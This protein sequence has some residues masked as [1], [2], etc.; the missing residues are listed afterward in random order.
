MA[1]YGGLWNTS[2]F[3]KLWVTTH[4]Y[5]TRPR[6][7]GHDLDSPAHPGSALAPNWSHSGSQMNHREPLLGCGRL[8]TAGLT[9]APFC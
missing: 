7:V 3:P 4:W 2:R 5:V 9:S 1:V 6:V 8:V